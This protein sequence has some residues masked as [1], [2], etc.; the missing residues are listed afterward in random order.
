MKKGLITFI[1]LV[2]VSACMFTADTRNGPLQKEKRTL[3]DFEGIRT[4]GVFEVRLTQ[5]DTYSVTVEA[6]TRL[7]PKIKTEVK[8]GVLVLSTTGK[9]HLTGPPVERV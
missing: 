9:Q 7:L 8:N 5:S 2:A 3:R 1:I 6:G 4:G